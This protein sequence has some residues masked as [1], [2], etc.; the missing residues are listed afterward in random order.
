[1]VSGLLSRNAAARYLSISTRTAGRPRQPPSI[2]MRGRN[3]AVR[4]TLNGRQ[5]EYSTGTA[6]RERALEIAANIWSRIQ[7]DPWE[8]GP[9]VYAIA[10]GPHFK[11]G[12][13]SRSIHERLL[14]L[15]TGQPHAL[16]LLGVL[17]SNPDDEQRLA[18]LFA[19]FRVRGE[20]YERNAQSERLIRKVCRGLVL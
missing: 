15:Q 20:W 6:D 11:I 18:K 2:R 17:S 1:M 12:R 9:G 3:Y 14:S 16:T 5:L 7:E 4:F 19:R 10:A 13:T 8:F